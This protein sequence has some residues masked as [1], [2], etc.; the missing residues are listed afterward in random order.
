ML[1]RGLN[2]MSIGLKGMIENVQNAARKT[3]SVWK[4]VKGT[5]QEITGGSK[6]QAD[7]VEEAASSVNEMHFALKEIAGNV[8]NLYTTSEAT[9]SSVIE[10]AASSDEV[11]KTIAAT[12]HCHRRHVHLHLSAVRRGPP[13]R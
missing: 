1:G 6:V 3:E 10:M 9:T 12:V 11:A 13:D 2:R 8:E 4:E 7:A 5:S